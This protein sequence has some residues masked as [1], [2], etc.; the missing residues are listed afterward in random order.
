MKKKDKE[1]LLTIVGWI[2][3]IIMVVATLSLVL[4]IYL[5]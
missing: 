2:A 5:G 3:I 1:K 4:K